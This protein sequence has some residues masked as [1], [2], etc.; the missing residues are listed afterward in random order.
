MAER[1]ET[2]SAKQSFASKAKIRPATFSEN[3]EVNQLVTLPA[4]VKGF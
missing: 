1:S 4:G 3:K 2:E